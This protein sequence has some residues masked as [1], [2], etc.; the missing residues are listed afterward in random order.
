MLYGMRDII[1]HHRHYIVQMPCT[2]LHN[3]KRDTAR[4]IVDVLYNMTVQRLQI[5]DGC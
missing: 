1:I 2:K 5:C 4:A 3:I